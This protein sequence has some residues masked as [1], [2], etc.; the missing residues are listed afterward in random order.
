ML[1]QLA[2][3]PIVGQWAFYGIFRCPFVVPYVSCQN[4]PVLTCHGRFLTLFWGFWLL[5]PVSALLFGRAFC[6]WVCPGGF[7]NQLMGK[8]ISWRPSL[9]RRFVGWAPGLKYAGLALA[10]WAWLLLGQP[11]AAVPIRIG[12]FFESISLTFA[13]ANWLW[14]I[15]SIFVLTMLGSG[16]LLANA[17]CRYACP[18]GG[19]LELAKR[20]SLWRVVKTTGCND[21]D[22]CRTVC[23]LDTRPQEAN[24]TNCC[25]CLAVCPQDA[26]RVG[27]AQ[28]G[29]D[30]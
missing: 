15:R 20:F 6:G 13:H 11:R 24:C 12:G 25:D 8:L 29:V 9:G 2:A 3:L 27:R 28:G 26:I 21:C 19:L 18:T 1:S 16:L 10:L 17:W 22:K 4:C 23:E 5:L 14:L 30:A 7:A